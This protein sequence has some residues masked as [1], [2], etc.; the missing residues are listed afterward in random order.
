LFGGGM[1]SV[2]LLDNGNY[3]IYTFG[4]GLG[5]TEPTLREINPDYDVLWNY[6][7]TNN[8]FWY[9]TYKIPSMYP[10]LFSAVVDN[11]KTIDGINII[12]VNNELKFTI[13]NNSGYRNKYNYDFSDISANLSGLLFD[14]QESSIVIEPYQTAEL[15]FYPNDISSNS[16]TISL[17]IYPEH[18]EYANKN[19]IYTVNKIDILSGDINNDGLVNVIDVISLVN[20]VLGNNESLGSTDLNSDNQT[21]ILDIVF[22]VSLILDN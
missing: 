5:Q 19:L 4:N 18:H 2:Q 17:F 20:V 11:Y 12:E 13:T 22:L 8:A 7:G 6:Q 3:L 21:N 9:R 14:N 16:A 15:V 1:G 10:E